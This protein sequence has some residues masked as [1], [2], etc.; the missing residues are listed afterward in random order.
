M[1]EKLD[2]FVLHIP[3]NRLMHENVASLIQ[4]LTQINGPYLL[5]EWN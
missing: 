2:P 5:I 1:R 3:S 4:L